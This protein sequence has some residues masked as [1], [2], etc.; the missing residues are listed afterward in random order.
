MKI[1]I[2]GG[3]SFGTAFASQLSSCKKNKITLLVRD[4]NTSN[5]INNFHLNSKYFPNKKLNENIFASVE[6]SILEHADLVF[7]AI[8]TKEIANVINPLK[9]Y[10]PKDTLLVN[11]AKGILE[12]GQTIVEYL[13][14]NLNHQNVCSLKGASFSA[15]MI[16]D[17]PTLLTLGFK[18]KNQLDKVEKAFEYTNLYLD[19]TIDIRGVELLSAL[20]NIYAIL[21]GYMDAKY[22][23]VNTR[24]LFLTKTFSELKIILKAMGGRAET[25]DLSCG[26]GDFALTSLNDLSRNR[27]L[28]LLIGKGFYNQA[29]QENS[30]VLEGI[31]TISYVNE[32][33]S[34]DLRKKLP[35]LE[36]L[37]QLLVHNDLQAFSKNFNSLF[38]RKFTT[39]LTYGTY[40][41]LHY[42]HLEILRRAKQLGD[43]LI[44]GLSTDEFNRGKGK[45]CVLNY[46][47][48]KQLLEALPYVDMVI[49][50]NKWE[51]KVEDVQ[52]H[53]VD[54]FVM[55][56]D[57]EGKFDF[58]NEYCEVRYFPRTK[59]ISTSVLKKVINTEKDNK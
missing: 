13:E 18:E 9:K 45:E 51:Q 36:A 44:V 24:F 29:T 54:I 20:K 17:V 19:Y 2:I 33:I 15:E 52:N 4:K 5:E 42:G 3:G 26:L 27:T 46:E 25:L 31:K 10:L 57:W 32:I 30:V 7:I 22:N 34:K 14:E 39:V 11:M 58:L 49:P 48:R 8:P 6:Y 1:V 56:S 53:H 43:R 41:L 28:G 23:A 47:K 21:L 55:G 38:K 35:L 12:N 40:D 50:E 16:H 37:I 59:G